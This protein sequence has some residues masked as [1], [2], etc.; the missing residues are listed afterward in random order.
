MEPETTTAESPVDNFDSLLELEARVQGIAERFG[1]A[2]RAQHDAEQTAARLERVVSEQDQKI[3][4]L[5]AEIDE[6]RN[7]RDQVRSRI[8]ALL[9]RIES[10]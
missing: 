7:E 2:R 5:Q 10:L 8:E 9:G 3:V 1:E 4:R 6:L